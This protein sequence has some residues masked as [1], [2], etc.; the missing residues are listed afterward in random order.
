M[1]VVEKITSLTA[2]SAFE[3]VWWVLHLISISYHWGIESFSPKTTIFKLGAWN[4]PK[5]FSI[6]FRKCIL[7][8]NVKYWTC[9]YGFSWLILMPFKG[10]MIPL[11]LI[12]WVM[13][14]IGTLLIWFSWRTN[15]FYFDA[16]VWAQMT[17]SSLYAASL[18]QATHRSGLALTKTFV[19]KRSN[20]LKQLG[21]EFNVDHV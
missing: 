14:D 18:I 13:E 10:Q 21:F 20:F 16:E 2:M 5:F 8:K 3:F 1:P 11:V 15:C 17:C 4:S 6:L 12:G 19:R 7:S 9:L